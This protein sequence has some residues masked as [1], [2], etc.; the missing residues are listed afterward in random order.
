[1]HI[2]ST[3]PDSQLPPHILL[4]FPLRNTHCTLSEIENLKVAT[5]ELMALA[6][7]AVGAKESASAKA[8]VRAH[9]AVLF[10]R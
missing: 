9:L 8:K 3:V 1:M 2:T 10:R 6:A 7:L 5:E 4:E